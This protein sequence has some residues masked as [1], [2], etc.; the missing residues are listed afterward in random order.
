MLIAIKYLKLGDRFKF[1]NRKTV[2]EFV[3]DDG[4][5]ITYK[6]KYGER[7]TTW[8]NEIVEKI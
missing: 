5:E 4:L 7:T 8:Y 2:N 3:L 1:K 6:S